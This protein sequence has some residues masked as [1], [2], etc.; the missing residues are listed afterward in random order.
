MNALQNIDPACPL[1]V[2]LNPPHTPDPSLTF[3]QFTYAHPQFDR[4]ALAAQ[5]ILHRI[6]GRGGIWHAGA[7]TGYGFHEDGLA[8][9]LRAAFTLGGRVPW[10][11]RDLRPLASEADHAPSPELAAAE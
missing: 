2:S 6:Q 9:G 4:A 1:F 3:G 5:R 11:F 8:S 7:W 10:A